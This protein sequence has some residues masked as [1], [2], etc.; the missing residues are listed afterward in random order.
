MA[1]SVKSIMIPTKQTSVV[2]LP[3]VPGPFS[4]ELSSST[5]PQCLCGNQLK[6]ALARKGLFPGRE[7]GLR[8]Q[9]AQ[10]P[11]SCHTAVVLRLSCHDKKQDT[12]PILGWRR[13]TDA[14]HIGLSSF[15]FIFC[16]TEDYD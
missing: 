3:V 16:G 2:L 6:S 5:L 7:P 1:L 13:A 12:E 9:V 11:T 8:H 10:G 14:K 4:S 15:F